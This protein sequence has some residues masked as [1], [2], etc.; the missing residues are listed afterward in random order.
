MRET[1]ES[2][3]SLVLIGAALV[4]QRERCGFACYFRFRGSRTGNLGAV[5]RGWNRCS[6]VD[7]PMMS[8]STVQTMIYGALRGPMHFRAS[9]PIAEVTAVPSFA[10]VRRTSNRPFQEAIKALRGKAL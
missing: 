5:E 10:I 1:S 8:A 3:P 7:C 4:L 2:I 6:R 9:W